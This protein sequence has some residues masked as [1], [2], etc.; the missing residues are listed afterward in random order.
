[1]DENPYAS[2]ATVAVPNDARTDASKEYGGIGRWVYVGAT[3]AVTMLAN[4]IVG[5][6]EN[7]VRQ[8]VSQ[9]LSIVL[10]FLHTP[11]AYFRLKNIGTNPWWSLGMN[12][13]ILNVLI[14]ARCLIAPKGYADT[15]KLDVAGKIVAGVTIVLFVVALIAVI[16]W[17]SGLSS[18]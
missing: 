8:S 6:L 12:V 13:P 15:K 4:L 1:M 7:L 14:S 2:P 3:I 9:C 5:A 11:P 16:L 10:W 17:L 18:T